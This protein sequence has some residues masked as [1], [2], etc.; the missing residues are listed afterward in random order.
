MTRHGRLG[1]KKRSAPSSRSEMSETYTQISEADGARK[2]KR[3]V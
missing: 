2:G 3:G 1:R